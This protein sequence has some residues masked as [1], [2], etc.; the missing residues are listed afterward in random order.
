MCCVCVNCVTV[1]RVAICTS[2]HYGSSSSSRSRRSRRSRSRSRRVL[3]L[4]EMCCVSIVWRVAICTLP[5]STMSASAL[6]FMHFSSSTLLLKTFSDRTTQYSSSWQSSPSSS[7]HSGK[8]RQHS[9]HQRLIYCVTSVTLSG[10]SDDT[11][12]IKVICG[13]EGWPG[14]KLV[15]LP[16]PHR[17]SAY[18]AP[19]PGTSLSSTGHLRVAVATHAWRNH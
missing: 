13:L 5:S 15:V 11:F 1:W 3:V 10:S 19:Q 14:L 12:E 18:L 9:T 8:V 7:C 6:H 2:R 17:S 4:L 16:F